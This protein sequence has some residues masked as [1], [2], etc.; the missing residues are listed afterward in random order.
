VKVHQDQVGDH[1]WGSVL[2]RGGRLSRVT[3]ETA[4]AGERP[5]TLYRIVHGLT[6]VGDPGRA[7]PP[8]GNDCAQFARRRRSKARDGPRPERANSLGGRV[9]AVMDPP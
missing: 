9:D 2:D 8:R 7:G 5:T 1:R 4:V 3:C 6:Y